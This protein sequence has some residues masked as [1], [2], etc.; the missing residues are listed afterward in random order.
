[1]IARLDKAFQNSKRFVADA[2]HDLRTPLTILRGE[3]E[4]FA[5][6]SRL[7]AELR[8][9]AASMLEEAVHLSKIVEQLF[10]LSRLDAGEARTEWTRFDLAELAKTTADQM[11]LLARGQGHFHFL[12][13]QPDD[14]SRGRPRAA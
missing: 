10:T 4:S 9:R 13:N 11:N 5:E 6:D 12:R 2:S 1:M 3:L 8:E 7:T 14:P